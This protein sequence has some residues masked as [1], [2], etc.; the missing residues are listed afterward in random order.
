MLRETFTFVIVLTAIGLSALWGMHA[1]DAPPAKVKQVWASSGVSFAETD[2]LAACDAG[3]GKVLLFAS[4]KNGNR[5]DVFDAATGK[6]MRSIGA[7]GSGPG[8]FGGPNGLVVAR[9]PRKDDDRNAAA[10]EQVLF[11]IERDNARVQCFRV[12]DFA[13]IGLFGADEL[14]KPYGGD[15]SYGAGG[16]VLYVT[17]AKPRDGRRVRRYS[18]SLEDG[19]VTAKFLGSFAEKRGT[20]AV[21]KPE[22]I[23]VDDAR[24]RVLV[25]DEIERDV[26]VF[27]RDGKF[28]GTT[29]GRGQV[30]VEPEGIAMI[31]AIADGAV[32]VTDQRPSISVWFAYDRDNFQPLGSFTGDPVV[33]NTDGICVFE[34]PFGPF[35]KGALFAVNDDQDVHAFDLADIAAALATPGR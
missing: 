23:L 11:V 32:I 18:V 17:D 2:S 15:V 7:Q 16:V 29:F 9:M 27:T 19:K 28:T 31:R 14:G 22:S 34:Q 5:I 10:V 30:Q 8:Q 20:G 6:F 1:E 25:C 24:D 3:D 26:K 33:A 12:S 21:E 35:R 13:P 4:C